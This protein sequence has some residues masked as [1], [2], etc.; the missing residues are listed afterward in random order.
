[1]QRYKCTIKYQKCNIVIV[2]D[3]KKRATYLN[4]NSAYVSRSTPTSPTLRQDTRR[5]ELTQTGNTPTALQQSVSSPHISN[6]SFKK[7]VS[8]FE[9]QCSL[10]MHDWADSVHTN[11]PS[12]L[13][14][15]TLHTPHMCTSPHCTP[16]KVHHTQ[17]L[18]PLHTT[19][20]HIHHFHFTHISQM[21]AIP[22]KTHWHTQ[23]MAAPNIHTH[24]HTCAHKPHTYIQHIRTTH[25]TYNTH[26]HTN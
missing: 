9:F 11:T 2:N 16:H 22:Y 12:S 1:M 8:I 26:T 25:H 17:C 19:R 3:K 21:Q 7:S 14:T 23:T 10:K 18:H 4:Q 24:A 13:L 15:P 20:A 5:P 6:H